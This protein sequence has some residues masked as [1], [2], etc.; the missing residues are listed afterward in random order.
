M[1]FVHKEVA[2]S[3]EVSVDQQ[4][5]SMNDHLHW[6][7]IKEAE[8]LILMRKILLGLVTKYFKKFCLDHPDGWRQRFQGESSMN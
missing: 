6:N 5:D 1:H 7:E 8:Q 2:H 4:L 3:L